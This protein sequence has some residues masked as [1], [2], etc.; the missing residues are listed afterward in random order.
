MIICVP[1]EED[2]Q[3]GP[4]WGRARRV[5]V[6]Q[7]SGGEIASWEEYDVG[8]DESHDGPEGHGAHHAR[9][10]RFVREHGVQ[11]VV[12]GGMGPGMVHIM[13]KLGIHVW[14]S[15]AGPARDAVLRVPENPEN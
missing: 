11:A 2:G 6:A 4:H 1:V 10:V 3:V 9:I 8:W 12:V 5:A 15:A 14:H 13:A 7:V